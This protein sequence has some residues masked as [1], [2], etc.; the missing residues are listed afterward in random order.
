VLETLNRTVIAPADLARVLDRAD[1][2]R[3][4]F[5]GPS[6]VIDVGVTRRFFTGATRRAVEVPRP[7]VH[8]PLLRRALRP[9]RHRP[10]HP[11]QPRR[12]HHPGQRATP[13]PTPQPRRRRRPTTTRPRPA[14]RTLIASTD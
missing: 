1:I 3:V 14:R 6:R 7:G 4:V 2:E 11:P 9:L 10:P 8:P 13:L 5:D 12:A